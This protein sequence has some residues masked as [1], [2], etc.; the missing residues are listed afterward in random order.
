MPQKKLVYDTGYVKPESVDSHAY[1][2]TELSELSEF[3]SYT[4]H[5]II[6]HKIYTYQY[7]NSNYYLGYLHLL[8]VLLI[9]R[10]SQ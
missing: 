7:Y 10:L 6:M 3:C 2:S 4:N 9:A 5:N 1:R 8:H